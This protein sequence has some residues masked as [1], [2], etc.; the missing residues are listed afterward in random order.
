MAQGEPLPGLTL[1]SWKTPAYRTEF[2]MASLAMLAAS[3]ALAVI[4]Y[5]RD[6]RLRGGGERTRRRRR[7]AELL[8]RLESGEGDA[9][10]FYDAALEYMTLALSPSPRFEELTA[11]L[12]DRRDRLKYGIGTS[13]P[14]PDQERAEILASLRELSATDHRP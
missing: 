3:S 7:I 8:A 12:S 13:R 14:I 11:R 5:L 2:L 4:L 6:L 9:A 10:S 1:R